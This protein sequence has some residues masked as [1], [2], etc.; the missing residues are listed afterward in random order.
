MAK[1]E[2]STTQ[3]VTI[4]YETAGFMWRCI[5][6]LLDFAFYIAF[7]FLLSMIFPKLIVLFTFYTYSFWGILMI[8]FMYYSVFIILQLLIE[9][10]TEGQTLGK[11]ITGIKIL[12]LDGNSM[13]LNKYIIRFVYNYIDIYFSFFSIGTILILMSEKNQRLGDMIA[14]TTVI[15]LKPDRIVTLDDLQN[16]PDKEDYI[17]K[18]P[19]VTR[20]TDEEMLALK[21]LLMRYQQYQ[22]NTYY[23]ILRN[24]VNKLKQQMNLEEV[25]LDD[26]T[27]L[28]E[29][30]SEYVI[31]TR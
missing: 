11:K 28:R 15:K 29:I 12:S 1:I 30:I 24:T 8:F 20:Y 10:Y 9:K 2:V 27:F 14:N 21:N 22:N 4:Q 19:Q 13:D 17:P 26:V 7:L 23:T 3:N 6:W 18:Y 5:A 16:L 25:K 31:L